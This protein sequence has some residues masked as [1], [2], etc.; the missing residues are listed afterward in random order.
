MMAP[1]TRRT[2]GRIG[3]GIALLLGALGLIITFYPGAEAKY[4]GTAAGAAA[5][6]LLSPGWPTRLVAITLAVVFACSARDG[7]RCGLEY[8]QWRT[9]V[10]LPRLQER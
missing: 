6:G 1:K 7:Y 10:F 3:I 4:F 5:L 9:D 8:Q 2:V